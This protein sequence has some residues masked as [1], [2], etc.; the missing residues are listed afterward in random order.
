[1]LGSYF[2]ADTNRLKAIYTSLYSSCENASVISSPKGLTEF[3]AG[4]ISEKSALIFFLNLSKRFSPFL[5]KVQK[6]HSPR[7]SIKE[8]TFLNKAEFRLPHNPLLELIK[9]INV[10]VPFERLRRVIFFGSIL[11]TSFVTI[12]VI[13]ET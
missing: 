3:V 1:M 9:R 2:R 5:P 10:F 13:P 11:P 6:S 12:S 7:A 8:S 4:L